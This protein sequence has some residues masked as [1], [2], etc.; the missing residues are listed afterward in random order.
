VLVSGDIRAASDEMRD[1]NSRHSAGSPDGRAM[2][3]VVELKA[4]TVDKID[5]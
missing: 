1:F 4:S 5:D 3:D 2:L